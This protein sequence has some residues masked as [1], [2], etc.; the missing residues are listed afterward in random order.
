MTS[1]S[2]CVFVSWLV[3]MSC[4]INKCNPSP[5]RGSEIAR[6]RHQMD[7]LPHCGGI[8]VTKPRKLSSSW[9]KYHEGC[10][11]YLLVIQSVKLFPVGGS[12]QCGPY[13]VFL[14]GWL[15]YLCFYFAWT[16]SIPRVTSGGGQRISWPLYHPLVSISASM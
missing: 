3:L 7:Q 10:H 14:F 12:V 16:F 11:E 1:S 8:L 13:L 2:S 5:A 9:E 6:I 15:E 4:V